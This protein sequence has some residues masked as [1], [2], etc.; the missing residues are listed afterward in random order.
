MKPKQRILK[1]I[2]FLRKKRHCASYNDNCSFVLFNELLSTFNHAN[3]K[4][5]GTFE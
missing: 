4:F 3:D 2:Y 5:I 1:I